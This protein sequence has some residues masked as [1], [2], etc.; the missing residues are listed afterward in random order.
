[1]EVFVGIF[2]RV[3]RFLENNQLP[4][5]LCKIHI[6]L[7]DRDTKT[8]RFVILVVKFLGTNIAFF[9]FY[10]NLGLEGMVKEIQSA[11]ASKALRSGKC[12]S[13]EKLALIFW[14]KKQ[15][16]RQIANEAKFFEEL[17]CV[18]RRPFSSQIGRFGHIFCNIYSQGYANI[19]IMKLFIKNNFK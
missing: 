3:H 15:F 13:Q 19:Q 18:R 8:E 1:M 4:D 17:R 16:G 12:T 9:H 11:G 5:A 10:D 14:A 2:N 7:P 6:I